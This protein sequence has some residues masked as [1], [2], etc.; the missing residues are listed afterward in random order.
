MSPLVRL[1]LLLVAWVA[2]ML[3]FFLFRP[4]QRQK[5]VTV[6]TKARWGIILEG[7]GFWTTYAHRPDTWASELPYWRFGLAL[8][9]ALAGISLAWASV[10]SLGRQWRIDAGLNADHQLVR[11]GPYRFVR[12]P[13]YA[14]MLC[15]LLMG[16]AAVGT[17]P[18][19][20]IALVLFIAGTEIRVRTED[21]LL[22]GRFAA[23]FENWR[24][25]VPAYLPYLR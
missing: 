19:W 15:M 16:I 10:R 9:L 4:K 24:R 14:A 21:D 2:W 8:L 17:L 7:L 1:I 23:E 25:S 18:G 20:P 13:I 6:A 5:A 3:T 12:H 11:E 22:R